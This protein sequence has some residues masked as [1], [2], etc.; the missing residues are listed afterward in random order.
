M[1]TVGPK[2]TLLLAVIGATTTLTAA[3]PAVLRV[4]LFIVT[5]GTCVIAFACVGFFTVEIFRHAN[6]R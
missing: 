3:G 5:I 2:V 4:A 1:A 6:R